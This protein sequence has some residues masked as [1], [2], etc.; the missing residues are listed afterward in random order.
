MLDS[1]NKP[2]LSPSIHPINS[3]ITLKVMD[4]KNLTQE[5]LNSKENKSMNNN[6]QEKQE[7]S[8]DPCRELNFDDICDF[9]YTEGT[10]ASVQN[11]NSA[12]KTNKVIS[13]GALFAGSKEESMS[14]IQETE[15]ETETDSDRFIFSKRV[16]QIV[17]ANS[18]ER[19]DLKLDLSR[20][21]LQ[22]DMM[23]NNHK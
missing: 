12:L 19:L 5:C 7:M 13:N 4:I 11:E 14:K 10:L 2:I 6:G 21:I 16:H 8:P 18:N 3:S 1:L 15:T 22:R 17:S 23:N 20:I 9:V